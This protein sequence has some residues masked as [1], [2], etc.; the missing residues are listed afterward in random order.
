M[1]RRT[2]LKNMGKVFG[3]AV[4]TPTFLSILESC[5]NSQFADWTP[6]FFSQDQGE[7]VGRMLDVLLPKTDTPSATELNVHVFIDELA[8]ATFDDARK[9]EV[10]MLLNA[11]M[12]Q[13]LSMSS[14]DSPNDLSDEMIANALTSFYGEL[15]EETAQKHAE[16]SRAYQMAKMNGEE[17]S[18][19][20]EVAARSF[21]N[22][23]RNLAISAYKNTEYIGEEVLA[24]LPVPGP[25]VGCADVEELTQGRAWSL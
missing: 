2:A 21:A 18:L 16:A 6:K 9:A 25:Y 20:E 3:F 7:F 10:Q 24:Y 19:E 13:T 1:E 17:A 15:D 4:A 23:I 14:V 12:N 22:E 8:N 11:C 5:Q